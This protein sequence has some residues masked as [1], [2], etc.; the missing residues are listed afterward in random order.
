MLKQKMFFVKH[1]VLPGEVALFKALSGGRVE[2]VI[3]HQVEK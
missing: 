3:E 2:K 1:H